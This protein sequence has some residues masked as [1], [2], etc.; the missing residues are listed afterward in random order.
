[1][2]ICPYSVFPQSFTLRGAQ[3]GLVQVYGLQ[4]KSCKS[5]T[6]FGY[7]PN[8]HELVQTLLA[9]GIVQQGRVHEGS[10]RA[11]EHT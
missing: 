4:A 1:M 5:L 3:A 7:W 6:E 10:P 8:A 9:W 11:I 2:R